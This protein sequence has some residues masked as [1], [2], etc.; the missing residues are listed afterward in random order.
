MLSA[1]DI[2][3]A[4]IL[5]VDDSP[6]NILLLLAILDQEGYV[7]VTATTQPQEVAGLHSARQFD[8]ILL[9]IQMPVMDGFKV[10]DALHHLAQDAW[11]PVLAITAH[12]DHKITALE[13]GAMDF[14][15]KPFV[16]D[17]ILQRIHKMLEVR[18]LFNKATHNS[19]AMHHLALH[20]PLTG[21]PNRRLLDD[22][23]GVALAHAQRGQT[24]VALM[25]MDLDGF[26]EVNDTWGHDCGDQLLQLVSQRL[27]S[28]ARREDTVA[29]IGGDEFILV[30]GDLA[31][32][33]D[34]RAIAQK[35]IDAV[36]SPY[37]LC[38]T[39]LSITASIGIALSSTT[40][41]DSLIRLADAALYQA[42]RNG[43][44]RYHVD[45]PPCATEAPL[46]RNLQ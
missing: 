5:I 10:M 45:A 39:E 38:D 6:D 21:L 7:N 13:A 43:K 28:A 41:A 15:V 46:Q 23:L 9:D 42:K 35:M 22:R 3:A 20:D 17:E 8:L 16:L 29:R 34:V 36:A 33:Q 27:L 31:S 4:K 26:K 30:V 32:L 24:L 11:L 19:A 40:P 37:T 12:P 18:L 2:Y 14:M 1:E 25:Y 44:N